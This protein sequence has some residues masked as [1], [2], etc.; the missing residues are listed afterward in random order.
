MFGE[1]FGHNTL[2]KLVVYFGT[3]FNNIY[4]DRYDANGTLIQR[5]KV[6]LNYGPRDKFL[7]R[8]DGNPDL[9][10]QVAIQLPRMTFEMTGLNYDP[11]R[12]FPIVNKVSK[13]NP[14][15]PLNK[16]S[17]YSPAPYNIYFTLS[18]MVKNV[19]DGTFIVEQIL[20]YFT[21][22][23]QATL[24]LNPDLD[25]KYDVPI[26]L[27]NVTHEDTYEGAFTERRAI[28]WTLNFTMKAWL[29]GPTSST[30]S[31]II[32]D[33][34]LN[35][36]IGNFGVQPTEEIRIRPGQ[37]ANG[38][39]VSSP[40]TLYTYGISA[41]NSNFYITE[42]LESTTNTNN[43]AYIR[44]ANSSYITAYDVGGTLTAN[45]SVRG[46]ISR[47][48]ATITSVTVTPSPIPANNVIEN[49]TWGFIVDLI[50]NNP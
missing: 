10:R 37:N 18:I 24:N 47:L 32:K 9:N 22:M 29:F 6:P 2:R 13:P 30:A 45:S 3:L 50:E 5:S 49:S 12:K 21:P 28:I 41:A 33:I 7:A 39:P 34:N 42:R 46:S 14:I 27:D 1:P 16:V 38:N 19:M 44:T 40:P 17:Q 23:W 43:Y 15:S 26:S 35:F 36:G 20:P 31:G 8:L 4:L 48:P 11:T 25:L